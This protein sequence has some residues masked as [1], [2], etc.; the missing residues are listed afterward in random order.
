MNK[1]HRRELLYILTAHLLEQRGHAKPSGYDI[2]WDAMEPDS[3]YSMCYE[4]VE[5][6]LNKLDAM[7]YELVGKNAAPAPRAY[8]TT[9][10]TYASPT[11]NVRIK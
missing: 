11:G 10:A 1:I 4:D 9:T 6:I 3:Q 2:E 7:G 5:I 8:A